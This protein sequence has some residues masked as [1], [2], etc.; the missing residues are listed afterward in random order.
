MTM[1]MLNACINFPLQLAAQ[2]E[3][4]FKAAV[5]RGVNLEP[6]IQLRVVTRAPGDKQRGQQ[7]YFPDKLAL[8]T[9]LPLSPLQLQFHIPLNRTHQECT[10]F[11]QFDFHGGYTTELTFPGIMYLQMTSLYS[12]TLL[13]E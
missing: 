1:T 7:E 9:M 3:N 13:P 11:V 2:E 5:Q 10:R 4:E 6:G 8:G 12:H